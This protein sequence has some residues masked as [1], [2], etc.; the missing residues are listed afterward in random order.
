MMGDGKVTVVMEVNK[1]PNHV[2]IKA[3]ANPSRQLNPGMHFFV[4]MLLICPSCKPVINASIIIYLKSSLIY[5]VS[6]CSHCDSRCNE[7]TW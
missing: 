2:M 3:N 5:I 7:T 4:W 6:T 1:E